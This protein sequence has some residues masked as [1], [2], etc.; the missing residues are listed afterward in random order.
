MRFLHTADWH[1]GRIFH[2]VHLTGD[3]AYALEQVLT[4]C[5]EERVDAVLVSGDIYDRAVPPPDAVRL[6]DE[7]LSRLVLDLGIPVVVIAG[8]HDSPDRLTF[9]SRLLAQKG[10]HVVGHVSAAPTVLG[11]QDAHGAVHVA[12]IPFAEPQVVRDRLRSEEILDHHSAMR[13]LLAGMASIDRTA[14]RSVLLAHTF[15]AGGELSDSERPLSVG[16]IETVD[17]S[18]FRGFDYVALGHLHRAQSMDGARLHYPGALLKYSFAEAAQ[19]KTV[20]LLDMDET[21]GCDIRRIPIRPLH[22]VRC[23]EG[24]LREILG[25]A[26]AVGKRDD[27]FLVRLLDREP[28]LDAMGK[29]RSA[30]PNVLHLERP[31]LAVEGTLESPGREHRGMKDAD[32]FAAFFSQVTGESLA[33]AHARAYAE[34]VSELRVQEREGGP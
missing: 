14:S 19:E 24:T 10:L 18:L 5:R 13:S 30:F 31:H 9:G 6:L 26:D 2:G 7:V 11:F 33:D 1:L 16:G 12:A 3:Q 27:Y 29:L 22:D 17:A 8:N 34:V 23:L 15:V 4:M 28:V 25:A 20:S 21:G 32:L